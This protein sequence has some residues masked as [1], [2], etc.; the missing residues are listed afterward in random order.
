MV[1]KMKKIL[2][3]G[4]HEQPE[5]TDVEHSET[6]ESTDEETNVFKARNL[7][8]TEHLQMLLELSE[9]T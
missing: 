6:G 2:H 4:D 1:Q 3:T 8:G 7:P 5:N 9:R